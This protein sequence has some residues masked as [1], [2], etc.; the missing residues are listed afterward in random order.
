VESAAPSRSILQTGL[1]VD[2]FDRGAVVDF[3]KTVYEPAQGVAAEWTGDMASCTAGTTSVNYEEAT[4]RCVNY[5]RA[6]TGLPGN[7]TL[8]PTK[9]A[10]DQDAALMF[11]ANTALSHSPPDTW[12]CWTADGAEAAGRSNIALGRHGPG[13]INAY[14]DDFGSS[15]FG[16]GHRRW[17]LY[18]PLVEIGTG[19]TDVRNSYYNGSNAVWV[20]G[21]FG[22]R[23]PSPEWVAWPPDGYVPYA[24]VFERWSFSYPGADFS[25]ATVTVNQGSTPVT[26]TL[27][28]LDTRFIGDRTI[29]WKPDIPIGQKPAQDT[30]YSVRIENVLISSSPR[31]YEYLVTVIDPETGGSPTPTSTPPPSPTATLTPTPTPTETPTPTATSLPTPSQTP[32]STPTPLPTRTAG[33]SGLQIY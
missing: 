17:L 26:V 11:I 1:S 28:P 14:I 9:S 18:P 5:F 24:V 8:N 31:S 20:I 4:L 2:R 12:T 23:P 3:W 15:N 30:T 25:E 33:V 7:V 6:M 16:V 13:A 21:E 29:V 32:T 22:T 27:E 19:S 10:K